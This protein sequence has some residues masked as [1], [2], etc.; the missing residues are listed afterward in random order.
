MGQ[1]GK[2]SRAA[3]NKHLKL[4]ANKFP[5]YNLLAR[6]VLKRVSIL[7]DVFIE[8][9]KELSIIISGVKL[10]KIEK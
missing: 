1:L 8:E 6:S 2:D 9:V 10:P 4:I 7:N 5:D 3:T